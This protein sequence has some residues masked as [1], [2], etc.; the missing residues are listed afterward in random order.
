[1]ASRSI[2]CSDVDDRPAFYG[3]F[4]AATKGL[5]PDYGGRNLDALNDD[6]RDLH[7]P[8]EL[9]LMSAE[10]ARRELGPWF[11]KVLHVLT[12]RDPGDQPVTAHLE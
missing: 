3:A 8:L 2:D 4:F 6:L 11:D 7:E 10:H 9:T 5:V 1:M 12:R